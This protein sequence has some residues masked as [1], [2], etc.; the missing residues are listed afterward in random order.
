MAQ[1]RDPRLAQ[2]GTSATSWI[3]VLEPFCNAMLELYLGRQKEDQ[4][5]SL[6][7]LGPESMLSCVNAEKSRVQLKHQEHMSNFKSLLLNMQ[8]PIDFFVQQQ[9]HASTEKYAKQLFEKAKENENAMKLLREDI[10]S[11][12][13]EWRKNWKSLDTILDHQVS[14]VKEEMRAHIQNSQ[15]LITYEV[16]SRLDKEKTDMTY[17]VN[18][19][20][21]SLSEIQK[22]IKNLYDFGNTIENKYEDLRVFQAKT[23]QKVEILNQARTKPSVISAYPTKSSSLPPFNSVDTL[24]QIQQLRENLQDLEDKFVK[25]EN[26]VEILGDETRKSSTTT[27]NVSNFHNDLTYLRDQ[28]KE[29][30]MKFSREIDT[31]NQRLLSSQANTVNGALTTKIDILEQSIGQLNSEMKL[32]NQTTSNFKEDV[33]VLKS[34]ELER[35]ELTQRVISKQ[36]TFNHQFAELD[37]LVKFTSDECIALKKRIDDVARKAGQS[38]PKEDISTSLEVQEIKARVNALEQYLEP[39]KTTVLKQQFPQRIQ[40]L[41]NELTASVEDNKFPREEV[42]QRLTMIHT[43]ITQLQREVQQLYSILNQPRQTMYRQ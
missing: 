32:V 20:K 5:N 42:E 13:E 4:L 19:T 35:R 33:S 11:V 23:A 9:I 36:D 22:D 34:S 10:A 8:E 3:T 37:N 29:T 24:A 15:K 18:S 2:A 21:Q 17:H 40:K 39:F 26:Q 7:T 14:Q 30:E 41:F 31:I 27:K 1:E 43:Q 28:L 25:F 38:A 12:R 16:S 6:L